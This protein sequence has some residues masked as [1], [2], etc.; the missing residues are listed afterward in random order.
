MNTKKLIYLF[1]AI[2]VIILALFAF[3]K[4][5]SRQVVDD[6][7]VEEVPPVSVTNIIV[8]DQAGNN[9]VFVEEVSLK[10]GGPGGFVG[11]YRTTEDGSTGEL[12]GVSGYLESGVVT[13]NFIVNLYEDET[14]AVGEKLI[15]L[16]HADDGDMIWN[17]DVDMPMEYNEG[18]VMV[19]FTILSEEDIPG[20]E[21]KL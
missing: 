21:T 3:N 12:I 20:F 17:K 6:G 2:V 16:V 14:F 8:P 10:E 5:L 4:F 7:V 18:L 11:I 15:A 9:S 1:I 13:N 19:T